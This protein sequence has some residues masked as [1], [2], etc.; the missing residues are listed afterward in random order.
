MDLPT[1]LIIRR[2]TILHS[3]I[4]EYI[5]HNKFFVIIGE[6]EKEYVGFFFINSNINPINRKPEQMKMQYLL[7]K[8][9][10][11]FLS[12]DSFLCCTQVSTITKAKLEASIANGNTTVK[13]TLRQ[14][15]IDAVLILVRGSKLFSPAEKAT[16][17][18]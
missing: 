12:Y 4:F 18:Q 16:F 7:R 8:V 2:G 11:S 10:Y 15:H 13:G 3:S 14:E 5:D 1:S 17:F 6:N 9:D